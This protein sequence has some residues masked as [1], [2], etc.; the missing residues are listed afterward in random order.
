MI[1][2]NLLLEFLKQKP[3]IRK[4]H[5]EQHHDD[6]RAIKTSPGLEG[7]EKHQS[8]F[9][10]KKRIANVEHC[11]V[12]LKNVKNMAQPQLSDWVRRELVRKANNFVFIHD[13]LIQLNAF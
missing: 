8:G 12:I 13:I 7:L 2:I 4:Q 1:S 10:Y 9:D 5:H 6:K 3:L 11:M